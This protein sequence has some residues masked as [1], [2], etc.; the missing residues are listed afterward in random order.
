M[1]N[2]KKLPVGFEKQN[3]GEAKF[4][5]LKSAMPKPGMRRGP[6][7]G[8]GG[9]AHMVEKPKDVKKTLAQLIKYFKKSS[10][11]ARA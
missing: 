4:K 6:G 3:A 7:P 1:N 9:M 11:L 5:E 10:K 8:P 2:D